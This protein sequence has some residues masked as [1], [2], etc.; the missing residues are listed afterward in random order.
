M[1]GLLIG[2]R[3]RG[4]CG[5]DT[6]LDHL[7]G[8]GGIAEI[9]HAVPAAHVIAKRLNAF[10]GFVIGQLHP[11]RQRQR[12]VTHPSPRSLSRGYPEPISTPTA[13]TKPPPTTTCKVARQ[14]GVCIQRFWI[15]AMA[16]SSTN[17]TQM[18]M[19]VAVQK[20]GIR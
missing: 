10:Q 1:P 17:T 6:G 4:R 2:P 14:N 18:A 20:C 13:K 3:G 15:Q 7:A 16:Q 5:L 9:A 12:L 8:N 11:V 19:I